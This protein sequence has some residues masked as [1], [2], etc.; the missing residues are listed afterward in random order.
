MTDI[1]SREIYQNQV[2]MLW[3]ILYRDV[4]MGLNMYMDQLIYSDYKD[5][6]EEILV[7]Y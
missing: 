2:S 3:T 1:T 4:K 5:Q 7:N 6:A